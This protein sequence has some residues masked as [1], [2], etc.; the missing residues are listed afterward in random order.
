MSWCEDTIPNELRS[1]MMTPFWHKYPFQTPVSMHSHT[2]RDL[3]LGYQNINLEGCQVQSIANPRAKR[4]SPARPETYTA[5]AE[6]QPIILS[7]NHIIQ[8]SMALCLLS[9]CFLRLQAKSKGSLG[10]RQWW[11]YLLPLSWLSDDVRM[12]LWILVTL[13]VPL[14]TCSI[15]NETSRSLHSGFRGTTE[16][17]KGASVIQIQGYLL[18]TT[19]MV[20]AEVSLKPWK[21]KD[22]GYK[23]WIW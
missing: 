2:L 3:E 8:S 17:M 10:V 16:A 1:T 23:Y 13:Q 7:S 9:V 14:E 15:S 6:Q 19:K 22:F 18:S 12:R 20:W 4:C 21:T 5:K 11:G